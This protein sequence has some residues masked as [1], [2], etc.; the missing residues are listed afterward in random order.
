MRTMTK[1]VWLVLLVPLVLA[2]GRPVTTEANPAAGSP[3]PILQQPALNGVEKSASAQREFIDANC[4]AC[5]NEQL[6][7]AGLTLA[8]IDIEKVGA[9]A[10]VWEKVLHKLD[11]GQMPPMGTPRPDRAASGALLSWLETELDLAAAANPDPGIVGVHRLNQTECANAVR[12][13]LALE[14]EGS[15]LLLPDEAD[16]GFDNIA[17]NLQL[18]PA[19]L[20]RYMS[21]ARKIRRLAV[22]DPTMGIVDSPQSFSFSPTEAQT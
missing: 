16:S 22:G 13:L 12:D 7:T 14:V 19:H 4:V 1:T 18:S 20:E 17:A 21:A 8:G 9:N 2:S 10:E 15:S 6:L 5:H 3:P 11:T